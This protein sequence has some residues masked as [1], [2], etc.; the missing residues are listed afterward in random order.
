VGIV[1]RPPDPWNEGW[2]DE[3]VIQLHPQS[4]HAAQVVNPSRPRLAERLLTRSQLD[5]LPE[6]EPLIDN[7]LDRRTV[8]LLGG[9]WGTLK[10]FVALDWAL[11]IATGHPWQG[12]ATVT[13]PVIYI[14]AE[15]AYGIHKR[16]TAWE[17]AWRNGKPTE[18]DMFH[19]FPAP[20]NLLHPDQVRELC[21]MATGAAL[22]VIDTVNRCAVTGD[23]NSARD[24]GMFV[25]ALYRIREA[26]TDGT[27]LP[28]HHTG[29]DKTTI[30][31]SSALEAGV[32]T[33]YQ[34]EG[35]HEGITLKRTKRKDGPPDDT[36]QLRLELVLDSGV[37]SQNRVGLAPSGNDLLSRF[38]SHFSSTGATRTQLREVV[39]DMPKTTFYRS[40]NALVTGGA[41]RN[42]GTERRPFYVMG[43]SRDDS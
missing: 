10:S 15:G 39:D 40:L 29:K 2:P 31:G 1:T 17:Y 20:I 33:V 18:D 11:S 26:T 16:V 4:D 30:R 14:A 24:M 43:V 28:L 36:H 42:E 37:V 34:T 7:T 19:V 3:Q 27:V 25:D 21:A 8:A 9:Y 22:I 5:S 12:R 6:P 38:Q 23:E 41:L 35:D 13:A 32:D